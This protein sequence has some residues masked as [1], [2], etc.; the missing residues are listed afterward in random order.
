MARPE[1]HGHKSPYSRAAL[2]APPR[3]TRLSHERAQTRTSL[4]LS[5]PYAGKAVC[6]LRA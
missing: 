1:D 4:R 5:R 6:P 3:G 2:A